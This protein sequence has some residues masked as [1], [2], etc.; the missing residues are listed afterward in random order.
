MSETERERAC[1]CVCGREIERGRVERACHIGA[2]GLQGRAFQED[3]KVKQ[4]LKILGL[5]DHSNPCLGV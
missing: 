5:F 3:G 1:M 4:L 2:K